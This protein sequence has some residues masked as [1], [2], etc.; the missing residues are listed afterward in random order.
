MGSDDSV[1]DRPLARAIPGSIYPLYLFG[2]QKSLGLT[3]FEL[4]VA[5][6][7]AGF[8]QL[9]PPPAATALLA[10]VAHKTTRRPAVR[11]RLWTGPGPPP[12]SIEIVVLSKQSWKT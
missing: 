9:V 5:H 6:A 8:V 10:L 3:T 4:Q 7:G 12:G 2:Q 1:R 11:F